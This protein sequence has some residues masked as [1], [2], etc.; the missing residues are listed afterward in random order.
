MFMQNDDQ[1]IGYSNKFF[2]E[3]EP[4]IH[5]GRKIE[6]EAS[7]LPDIREEPPKTRDN[8]YFQEIEN[9]HFIIENAALTP[10]FQPIL[11]FD[12]GEVFAYEGLI[13]GP[14]AS[15]LC[16]PTRLFAAAT[17]GGVLAELEHLC[18]R[19]I[20]KRFAQLKLDRRL[21][22]NVSPQIVMQ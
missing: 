18:C 13:R 6:T 7:H 16:M 8:H 14:A 5:T 9:L 1:D 19:R 10:F 17:K 21:F 22:L 20:I 15:S 3:T 2:D 12:T 4:V 11:K